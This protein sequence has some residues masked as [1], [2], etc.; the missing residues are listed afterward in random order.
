M[1][2]DAHNTGLREAGSHE[3]GIICEVPVEDQT[4]ELGR[5]HSHGRR[6]TTGSSVTTSST[7]C[8]YKHMRHCLLP[9]SRLV[10]GALPQI[11]FRLSRKTR[12]RTNQLTRGVVPD[13]TREQ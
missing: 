1:N 2:N 10:C 3:V 7:T 4:S 6:T 5:V 11:I 12:Q 13:K 8:S 9:G